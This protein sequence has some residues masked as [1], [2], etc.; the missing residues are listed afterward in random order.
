MKYR[1]EIDGLRAVAVLP[2]ILFHA[3]LET[4]SG[5]FVGVDVFF[6]LS[7]YL[8]TSIILNDLHGGVFSISSFYERRVRRILPALF[9]VIL[10]C[11]PF[12]WM[13]MFPDASITFGQSIVAT[14]IFASNMFFWRQSN[15]FSPDAELMPLL[16]TWSL[17][18]EEQYYLLF[19]IIVAAIWKFRKEKLFHVLVSLTLISLVLSEWGWRH[20]PRAN[21]Y[22][23]PTRAWELL[24][25]SI[26]ALIL[27]K[28]SVKASNLLATIGLVFILLSIC[29]FDH[30]TPFPSLYALLPVGG[31]ALIV[32]FGSK[33][34]WIAKL[35]STFPFVA[36]GLI[37]YSAY[38]WHQPVFAFARIRSIYDLSAMDYLALTVLSLVLAYFTWLFIEQPFRRRSN[39]ILAPRQKLFAMSALSGAALLVI[40][41][42]F[43]WNSGFAARFG[44][45]VIRYLDTQ[46]DKNPKQAVCLVMPHRGLPANPIEGCTVFADNDDTVDVALL[47]DSH[48]DALQSVLQQELKKAGLSSYTTTYAGCP[49]LP[50]LYRVNRGGAHKCDIFTD[51][52]ISYF[53]E[54][55]INTIVLSAR[56]TL[57]Y[58]GTS[59]DNQ[60]GGHE[61]GDNPFADT[62]AARYSPTS[63]DDP[64]RKA[65]VLQAYHDGLQNLLSR[66][67]TVVLI[68]P[69]PEAGWR[70][71]ETLAKMALHEGAQDP[72]LSTSL[73]VFKKRNGPILDLFHSIEHPR[74]FAVLPHE[75]LCNTQ[76]KDRCLN[77]TVDSVFYYD[78]DHLSNS[79][80]SLIAPTI[81]EAVLKGRRQATA[82]AGQ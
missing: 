12:A 23:A 21:F 70:V 78:D 41:V 74:L 60:E 26:C 63:P 6:V 73:A 57:Y 48:A 50:G 18:V 77:G 11:L 22:L 47:G 40:G 79:G 82:E 9:F 32:V 58:Q 2:V 65:R 44:P 34:T 76:I 45:D 59:F 31:T 43:V 52:A 39:P 30:N 15:Y 38:L 71:P 29:L 1:A 56:W 54:A 51:R 68:Y 81:V 55:G 33:E 8:I 61:K 13:W 16:H 69:I 35:L 7:G 53:E 66:G 75:F 62:V 4:F 20:E 24:V 46:N 10:S 25:G 14:I 5:G 80:T 64:D 17:A 49:T 42:L 27:F 28:K 37:S 72:T 19:P 67:F 3:G 36:L